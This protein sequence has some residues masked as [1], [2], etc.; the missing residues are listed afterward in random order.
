[1]AKFDDV[2]IE[3]R[4][5]ENVRE[6]ITSFGGIVDKMNKKRQ[7]KN[8]DKMSKKEKKILTSSEERQIGRSPPELVILKIKMM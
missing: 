7:R 2:E 3:P 5:G 8:F 4:G 6:Y 1:M